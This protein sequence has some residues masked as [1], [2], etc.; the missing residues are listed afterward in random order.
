MINRQLAVN[1]AQL[2]LKNF[3]LHMPVECQHSHW[4][5]IFL[6]IL[7]TLISSDSGKTPFFIFSIFYS[8]SMFPFTT[9]L[10]S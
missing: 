4:T 9:V 6:D 8:V 10:P 2:T 7:I 5:D 1:G 3:I